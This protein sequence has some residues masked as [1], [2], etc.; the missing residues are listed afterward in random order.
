MNDKTLLSRLTWAGVL[1]AC[2]LTAVSNAAAAGSG[3]R[4]KLVPST[5]RYSPKRGAEYAYRVEMNTQQ[6]DG[7]KQWI[8][9]VYC[10]GIYSSDDGSPA[11]I[12]VIGKLFCFLHDRADSN[13]ADGKAHRAADEDVEFPRHMRIGPYGVYDAHAGRAFPFRG[14]ELPMLMSTILPIE[15]LIFPDVPVFY[16]S[17]GE[18]SRGRQTCTIVGSDLRTSRGFKRV[19]ADVYRFKKTEN[20]GSRLP[21][22]TRIVSLTCPDDPVGMGFRQVG[23]FDV[24][25][26][27]PTDSNMDYELRWNDEKQMKVTVRRQRGAQLAAIRTAVL[28][29]YPIAQWP[30]EM[31]RVPV[32]PEQRE[33]GFPDG[34]ARGLKRG[35]RLAV[36][37]SISTGSI[38]S[39][40][41]YLARVLRAVSEDDVLVRLDGSNEEREFD[42]R[43][44]HLLKR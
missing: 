11:E 6:T 32:R 42:Y 23:L 25:E 34:G 40:R 14:V 5:L 26:G 44:V 4:E 27:M 8:G 3:S 24:R 16:K 17:G 35:Q 43:S 12:V 31:K 39:S 37:I 1:A 15:E 30:A 2:C 36:T 13:G 28:Q 18:E 29:K 33:L 20:E 21:K 10:R 38:Q 7:R 22:V 41:T 9:H 19:T